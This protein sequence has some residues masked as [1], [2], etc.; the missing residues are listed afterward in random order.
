MQEQGAGLSTWDCGFQLHQEV[1]TGFLKKETSEKRLEGGEGW[2]Q[3]SGGIAFLA[4][5]S[6]R[7]MV[8]RWDPAWPVPGA[9]GQ[10]GRSIREPR[11]DRQEMELREVTGAPIGSIL[12]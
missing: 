4:Q 2:P 11:Q 5:V 8:L 1:R 12:T 9:R 6:P 7:G 3:T 10:C